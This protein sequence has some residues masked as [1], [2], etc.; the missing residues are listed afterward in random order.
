MPSRVI[1]AEINSSESLSKVSMEADLTF[2][3]LILA[4]DDYGRLD[5]RVRVLLGL[6]FPLRSEVTER[7]L[8]GW[9]DELATGP[10]PPLLRYEVDGRPYLALTGW[11]KHRGK[12]KRGSASKYPKPHPRRSADVPGDPNVC[13][14]TSGRWKVEGDEWKVTSDESQR[15]ETPSASG[16]DPDEGVAEIPSLSPKL[17]NVLGK[18]DGDRAEK[19][20]WL[21]AEWPL[22]YAEAER[23]PAGAKAIS[24][25]AIRYYRNYLKSEPSSKYQTKEHGKRRQYQDLDAQREFQEWIKSFNEAHYAYE[26]SKGRVQ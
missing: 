15:D 26:A 11:E 21:E 9:L 7:K 5:G 6:L 17:V 24:A 10:N 20:A 12:Q 4:A 13:K 8:D 22:I 18:L 19:L 14:V 3:A 16:A 23:D 2:R 25:I 1:R